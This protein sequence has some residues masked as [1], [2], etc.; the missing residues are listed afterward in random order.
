MDITEF[1]KKYFKLSEDET[2]KK[3]IEFGFLTKN[4][5]VNKTYLDNGV[6]SKDH[7]VLDTKS[8]KKDFESKLNKSKDI[9]D[10]LDEDEEEEMER[11]ESDSITYDDLLEAIDIDE[12]DLIDILVSN[13]YMADNEGNSWTKKGKRELLDKDEMITSKGFDIIQELIGT[14]EDSDNDDDEDSDEAMSFEDIKTIIESFEPSSKDEIND[15]IYLLVDKL[16]FPDTD[17]SD[18]DD[19]EDNDNE[20]YKGWSITK[21]K[22]SIY[23][24]KGKNNLKTSIRGD[25]YSLIDKFEKSKKTKR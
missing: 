20:S 13:G 14:N 22:T 9:L 1:G 4:Y 18:D 23:A 10:E 25:I 3:F 8:L 15:L 17:D 19:I 12:D 7:D 21:D 16:E 24:S 2:Y 6:L 11:L 5:K